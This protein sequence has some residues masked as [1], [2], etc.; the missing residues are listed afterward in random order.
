V[1]ELLF[2]SARE[3][4]TLLRL[5]ELGAQELVELSLTTELLSDGVHAGSGKA[6]QR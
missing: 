4:A 5:G 3:L 1:S 2:R 6:A